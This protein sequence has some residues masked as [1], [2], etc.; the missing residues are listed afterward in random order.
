[1]SS[2]G[3]VVAGSFYNPADGTVV[4]V[5]R[6]HQDSDF[7]MTGADEE[8]AAGNGVFGGED[9]SL[10]LMFYDDDAAAIAQLKTWQDE[11]TPVRFCLAG[12]RTNIVWDEDSTIR[13]QQTKTMT[14]LQRKTTTVTMSA[15]AARLK[16]WQGVNL[17]HGFVI[18]QGFNTGWADSDGN[19]APDGFVIPNVGTYDSIDFAA[20]V[21]TIGHNS[22]GN[23]FLQHNRP[24][25][26][27]GVNLT[28]SIEALRLHSDADHRF[29]VRQADYA[30]STVDT[31]LHNIT[32][33]GRDSANLS[34]LPGVYT[35][36]IYYLEL[37]SSS[38]LDTAQVQFPALRT[39]NN[40]EY[41]AG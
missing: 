6:V 5:N 4:Q 1:M 3:S 2:I 8:D 10:E 16:I 23:F 36:R 26:I 41:K 13:I 37:F 11:G 21:Y 12:Q 27:S 29:A 33:V 20:D 18:L 7:T 28:I 25:P 19:E 17:A 24:F 30:N 15:K 34:T 31:L 38:S 14:P 22:D 9:A 32:T 35:L 40:P 39:D